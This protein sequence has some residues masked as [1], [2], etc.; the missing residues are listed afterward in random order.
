MNDT[1]H[2]ILPE[3]SK[4]QQFEI[5]KLS[6]DEIVA[7]NEQRKLALHAPYDPL[8]GAGCCGPRVERHVTLGDAIDGTF[9]IPRS[10]ATQ[11]DVQ[12]CTSVEQW[13]KLRIKHDF[14]FWCASC[15]TILD[16][17]SGRLIN[18]TLNRPQRRVLR[19]LEEQRRAG[20]PLRLI[21]LKARQWGGSTLVQVYMA[22]IQLVHRTNWNSIICG[23]LLQTASAI[24]VM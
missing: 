21:L 8:T 24:K 3:Q 17:V 16:K 6:L 5:D 14:E 23:H 10:M 15:V 12:P 2:N 4:E 22:W 18:M 11:L 19:V 13:T 7:I 20:K 1:Y 9:L